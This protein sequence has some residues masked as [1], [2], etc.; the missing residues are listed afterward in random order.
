M[1]RNV[2][3][4]NSSVLHEAAVKVQALPKEAAKL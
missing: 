4:V 2:E 3:V 1:Q